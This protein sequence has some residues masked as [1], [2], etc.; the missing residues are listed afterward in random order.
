MHRDRYDSIALR[1]DKIRLEHAEY[2]D[3]EEQGIGHL[4]IREGTVLAK[5]HDLPTLRT[6]KLIAVQDNG[7]KAMRPF[8]PD[9]LP[10]NDIDW[11]SHIPLIAKAN[12]E[13]ARFDGVLQGM[14]NPLVL[15]SP[16]TTRE[17]LLSS[18]IEGTQATFEEILKYDA[19]PSKQLEP[20]RAADIQEIV[21]YREA[22][23]TAVG[24]LKK[25]PFCLNLLRRLHS[26][27][28][29]SVRGRERAPGEFRKIQNYIGPPGATLETATFVPPSPDRLME[30]LDNWEKYAHQDEKDRLVQLAVLKAQFEI[31]HPFL[32]G[33][34]R[35]GRMLV[36][37]FL[38]TTGL[39][40]SPMFYISAY[41]EAQR[42]VYYDRL[43]EI[44]K[45]RDWNGWVRFFLQAVVDQAGENTRKA[46]TILALYDRMKRQVAEVTRSH[47]SIQAVDTLF[48]NPVFSTPDFS[49]MSGIPKHSSLRLLAAL[50]QAGVLELVRPGS[51]RRPTLLAFAELIN[52]AEG[53]EV[54]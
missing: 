16:L 9:K 45:S 44:S 41:F 8:V 18:K 17:A 3:I 23:G 5:I 49:R 54:V 32:D 35:I 33:N 47:F 12:A 40:S 51:G 25:K 26:I 20:Q 14:V 38:Y 37:L 1:L 28:L 43:G 48:A 53:R 24:D 11:V 7:E 39:L 52:L 30:F 2:R 19:E 27:L 4:V 13:L 36:P 6:C 42:D 15:L 50:G 21:N 22:M 10:L 31:I 46:Q 34:G 29:S